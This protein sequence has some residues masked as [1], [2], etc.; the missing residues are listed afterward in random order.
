M[1]PLESAASRY[2][3]YSATWQ[4]WMRFNT[5]PDEIQTLVVNLLLVSFGDGLLPISARAKLKHLATL[6]DEEIE[7]AFEHWKQQ[8][9]LTELDDYTE[10]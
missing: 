9:Q 8:Q 2:S 5:L 6:N 4:R 7:A 10:P 3:K 1:T